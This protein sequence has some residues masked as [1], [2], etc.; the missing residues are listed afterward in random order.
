MATIINVYDDTPEGYKV[1]G[2]KFSAN[3]DWR[4]KDK[5]NEFIQSVLRLQ[6]SEKE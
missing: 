2:V 5:L 4:D 1:V 3:I 6:D